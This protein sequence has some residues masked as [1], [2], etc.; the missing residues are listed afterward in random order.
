MT[1]STSRTTEGH[2]GRFAHIGRR[3]RFPGFVAAEVCLGEVE[4]RIGRDAPASRTAQRHRRRRRRCQWHH[5]G[6]PG[7]LRGRRSWFAHRR[8]AADPLFT[9]E[10]VRGLLRGEPDEGDDRHVSTTSTSRT[11]PTTATGG[12]PTSSPLAW[13]WT[14]ERAPALPLTRARVTFPQTGGWRHRLGN[15]YAGCHV[16]FGTSAAAKQADKKSA[17]PVMLPW[18]ARGGMAG[19]IRL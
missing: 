7:L 8:R 2:G 4:S 12:R 11:L 13:M 14:S 9:R 3:R 17:S 1:R 19:Q 15:S 16:R 10:C 5:A 18:V 6:P